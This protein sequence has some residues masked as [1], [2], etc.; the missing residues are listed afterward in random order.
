MPVPALVL[1][2]GDLQQGTAVGT[3]HCCPQQLALHLRAVTDLTGCC[4]SPA[5]ALMEPA[6]QKGQQDEPARVCQDT[7]RLPWKGKDPACPCLVRTLAPWLIFPSIWDLLSAVPSPKPVLLCAEPSCRRDG[8]V[9]TP[10]TAWARRLLEKAGAA[11]PPLENQQIPGDGEGEVRRGGG[12]GVAFCLQKG[13]SFIAATL[14][15]SWK[16]LDAWLL[17]TSSRERNWLCHGLHTQP[18]DVGLL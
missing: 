11:Q 14:Q 4:S 18:S 8:A 3:I 13:R 5:H 2:C 1:S 15:L 7:L 9:S 17:L 6:K 12:W 16:H 10:G